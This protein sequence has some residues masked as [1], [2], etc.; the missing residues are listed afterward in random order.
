M[1]VAV[2]VLCPLMS[3]LGQKADICTAIGQVRFTPESG[4]VRCNQGCPLWAKSGHWPL[5]YHFV[6]ARFERGFLTNPFRASDTWLAVLVV[7]GP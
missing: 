3:A 5:L 7:K 1:S 2:P 4:H 6:S